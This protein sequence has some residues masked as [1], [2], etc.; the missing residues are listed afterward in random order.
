[1]YNLRHLT[2]QTCKGTSLLKLPRAYVISFFIL[3]YLRYL[4]NQPYRNLALDNN[5][6]VNFLVPKYTIAGFW[7]V[8]SLVFVA[9]NGIKNDEKSDNALGTTFTQNMTYI[10]SFYTF[11]NGAQPGFFV[12]NGPDTTSPTL[13]DV[14]LV[15]G[16]VYFHSSSH[17]SLSASICRLQIITM[18][19]VFLKSPIPTTFLASPILPLNSP[20]TASVCSLIQTILP[21]LT[22]C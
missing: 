8:D 10:Q 17:F 11:S 18:Y 6:A 4:A 2:L 3:V 19:I 15:N 22:I 1:M 21:T 7:Y 9:S 20:L 12:H 16:S 14:K 5:F 13:L